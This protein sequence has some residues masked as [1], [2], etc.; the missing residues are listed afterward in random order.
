M[1]KI[2]EKKKKSIMTSK[3]F[4]FRFPTFRMKEPPTHFPVLKWE[5]F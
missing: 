2:F 4:K 3:Y 1:Q 5:K